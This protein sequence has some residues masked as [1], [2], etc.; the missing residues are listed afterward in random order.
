MNPLW[1]GDGS[2][3]CAQQGPHC[4]TLLTA[5]TVPW[6]PVTCASVLLLSTSHPTLQTEASLAK[7]CWNGK[8]STEMWTHCVCVF[9]TLKLVRSWEHVESRHG[10]TRRWGG[11]VSAVKGPWLTADLTESDLVVLLCWETILVRF[12][13]LF[14]H[15]ENRFY[16]LHY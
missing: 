14:K 3:P 8:G 16:N 9:A 10:P 4:F 12:G 1:P 13:S 7:P 6:W 2:P 5:E 15:N 11:H